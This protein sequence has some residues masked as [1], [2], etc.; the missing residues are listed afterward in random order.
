MTDEGAKPRNRAD[1]RECGAAKHSATEDGTAADRTADLRTADHRTAGHA[2]AGHGAAGRSAEHGT[3][4]HG[5][6]EDGVG[7]ALARL[8]A[9][10]RDAAAAYA[11]ISAADAAL[12]ALAGE[13]VAGERVLRNAWARY[14]A[15][16]RALARHARAK[17][18]P[19]TQLVSG[20]RARREWLA[21]QADLSA[22]LREATG[23]LTAARQTVSGVKGEFAA[24]V[25]ARAEAV[26]ALRRLTAGCVAVLAE[27]GPGELGLAETR[28][29]ETGLEDGGLGEVGRGEDYVCAEDYVRGEDNVRGETNTSVADRRS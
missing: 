8:A 26:T 16:S 10:Q 6:A 29:G 15:A 3:V 5:A 12:Q 1:R 4:G 13:R 27:I 19:L 14:R 24:Q 20:F 28:P 17:P 18:G 25:Q 7:T 11:A 2:T 9:L 21:A 22:A 23:P